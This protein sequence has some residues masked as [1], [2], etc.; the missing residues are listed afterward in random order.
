MQ[1][2]ER[3]NSTVM[4]HMNIR[5][6]CLHFVIFPAIPMAIL[7]FWSEDVNEWEDQLEMLGWGNQLEKVRVESYTQDIRY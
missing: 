3:V 5:E 6:T 1:L 4:F 7:S 2:C